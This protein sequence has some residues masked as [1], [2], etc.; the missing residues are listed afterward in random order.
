MLD[1][2]LELT[3][4]EA[5]EDDFSWPDDCDNNVYNDEDEK[6]VAELAQEY[7]ESL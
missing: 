7:L 2:E 1:D 3:L 4:I 6:T 5:Q